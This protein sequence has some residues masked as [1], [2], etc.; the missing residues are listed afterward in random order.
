MIKAGIKG[1]HN[2]T[3]FA[4]LLTLKQLITYNSFYHDEWNLFIDA[5]DQATSDNKETIILSRMKF[6]VNWKECL[7]IKE[8]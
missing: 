6:P 8:T 1:D 3:L 2:K 5:L 4:Q 7:L